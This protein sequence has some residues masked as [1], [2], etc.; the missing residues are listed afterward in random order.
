MNEQTEQTSTGFGRKI[1][2]MAGFIIAL[3]ALITGGWFV[4][5]HFY[6]RALDQAQTQLASQGVRLTCPQSQIAGFPA[7][8]EWRC[9]R[10]AIALPNGASITGGAFQTVAPVWNPL[11]TIA[12]WIGPF[13][14]L[15]ATG[16]DAQIDSALL[17]ASVRIDTSLQL[18]RLSAVLD[19]FSVAVQGAPM[20]LASGQGAEVHVRQPT[21]M[22]SQPS[23]TAGVRD[24]GDLQVAGL[25][26][27][28]S[29]PFLG[30]VD[31]I[32]LSLTG[33]IDEL[34]R[35]R[36]VSAPDALNDWIDRSG[37]IQPIELRLRLDDHAI[38]LD[39]DVTIAPDRLVDFN[40]TIATN[41]VTAL[42]E[43]IGVDDRNSA[44]AIVA[45]A[46]IFGQRITIREDSA[47][48]L[49]LRVE[50]GTISIGPVDLGQ[51]PPLP[52]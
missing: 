13:E 1:R 46:T 34:A 27:G 12:E 19:P 22:E 6:G 21:T 47:T 30:G 9:Q 25:V 38:N 44:A 48:Q 23:T 5:A 7:R 29:S 15:S 18:E 32:D 28:F 51:L 50:R 31:Q 14:T 52:F 2:W 10:L 11:F 4:G 20:A 17:R 45:G 35:V 3:I 8:F 41:D 24:A 26:F 39:G 40:G 37:Q 36:A 49:P 33:M 42:V 16:F 43:L